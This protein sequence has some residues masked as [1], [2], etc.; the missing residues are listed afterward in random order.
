MGTWARIRL[1]FWAKPADAAR[2]PR[3]FIVALVALF[4]VLAGSAQAAPRAATH[5]VQLQSGVSLAEGEAAVRAADG[6][7]ADTLPIIKGLAVRLSP[8]ARTRLA[9]D[10]R[11][12]SVSVNAGIKSQSD[13]F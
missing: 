1:K 7:V 9:H 2:M 13:R 5:I 11:V 6:E 12:A 4:G 10:T 3:T 8:A